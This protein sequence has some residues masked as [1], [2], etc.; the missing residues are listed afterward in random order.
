MN[1]APVRSAITP[2]FPEEI[3][4]APVRSQ[5]AFEETVNRL[6]TAIRL[7]HGVLPYRDYAFVHPPGIALL[8]TPAALVGRFVG[9]HDAMAVARQH[10]CAGEVDGERAQPS[11]A[12]TERIGS[13]QQIELV[14]GHP[15][16]RDPGNQQNPGQRHGE[17]QQDGQAAHRPQGQVQSPWSRATVA[18]QRTQA[19][20][21]VGRPRRQP[22]GGRC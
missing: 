15:E 13:N 11:E 1:L 9:T 2:A 8:M 14:P 4:F 18:T 16:S 10:E 21:E 20:A 5:T 3:V 12:K 6:G 7:V 17:E 22:I 19:Q